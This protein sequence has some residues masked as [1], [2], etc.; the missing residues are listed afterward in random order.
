MLRLIFP[1]VSHSVHLI[2][3]EECWE[4]I[5]W[6]VNLEEPTT[7][8]AIRF[9]TWDQ[10]LDIVIR[11]DFSSW[12]WKDEDHFEEV[13]SFGLISPGRAKEFRDEGLRVIGLMNER[14]PPFNG[15]WESWRPDP[16]WRMPELP[17][18]WNLT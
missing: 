2:W 1:D 11:P 6:Y 3:R 4:L 13:Q 9:D 5:C 12:R 16:S 15:G 17:S 8:T 18:G 7:R 14:R 10:Q